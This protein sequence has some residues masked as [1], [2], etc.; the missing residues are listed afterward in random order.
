MIYKAIFI[1]TCVFQSLECSPYSKT[2]LPE[3]E[4]DGKVGEF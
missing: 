3:R 4:E 2:D 1:L